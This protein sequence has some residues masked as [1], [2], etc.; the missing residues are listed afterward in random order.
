MRLAVSNL[1][2]LPDEDEVAV[3]VLTAAGVRAI[4]VAPGTVWG[5]PSSV[6][7]VEA[8]RWSARWRQHG[9]DIAACQSLL[10]GH[11]ELEVFGPPAV[12]EATLEYLGA[13]IRLGGWLGAGVLVFG[14]PANRRSGSLS[15]AERER[16]AL[17]FFRAAGEL[18]VAANTVL[19]IE[20]NPAEYGADWILSVKEGA[21]FVEMVGH[22][23]IGLLVDA[24]GLALAHDTGADVE[25]A[26]RG[27]GVRHVHASEPF[28]SPLGATDVMAA[29]HANLAS[30]LRGAG[31]RGMVSLEMRR[32]T[33]VERPAELRRAVEHLK[34]WYG[35]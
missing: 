13:M 7:E 16:T 23:G 27:V 9:F 5:E 15:L 17:D 29:T 18:A 4:E 31:Y 25:R 24:G 34:R 14:S 11:P 20:P 21:A 26:V 22:P 19:C 12:R 32:R 6:S 1:A 35:D 10:Y 33:D 28:L 3:E 8:R 30:T 2:W